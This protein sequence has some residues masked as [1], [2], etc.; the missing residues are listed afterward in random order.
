MWNYFGNIYTLYFIQGRYYL[1][2]LDIY[3]TFIVKGPLI[4]LYLII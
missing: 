2:V 1:D 3:K 4:L